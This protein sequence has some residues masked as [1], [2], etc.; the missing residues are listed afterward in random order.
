MTTAQKIIKYIA[1]G[2]AVAL[3]IGIFSSIISVLRI[4]T[5]FDEG[6]AIT[7]EAKIY[8]FTSEIKNLDFEIGAAEFSVKS[9]DRIY[10][11]SNL[12]NLTVKEKDSVVTARENTKYNY[13][14][15]KAFLT[16][17]VPEDYAFE[18]VEIEAGAGK[19]IVNSLSCRELSLFLGAGDF[20]AHELT[21][22]D[23]CHIQGGV[24]EISVNS[25]SISDLEMEMGVGDLK[26]D[27]F[28]LGDC[29]L[30]FGVGNADILLFGTKEDY[31]IKVEKGLG[32]ITLDGEKL[33]DDTTVG[34]G[35]AIISVEGGIGNINIKIGE[36]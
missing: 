8:E 33:S 26:L 17:Y 16:L 19:I 2:L 11:E 35:T 27:A 30:S 9:A 20:D 1:I 34:S 5:F 23:K 10:I 31:R 22:T 3:I 29:D 15:T 28:L 25:G 36:K 12:K 4:I 32:S 6:D 18:S 7:D 24:G 14:A 21:V 13:K